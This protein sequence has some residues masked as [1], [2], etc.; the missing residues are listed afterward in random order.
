M[1]E[2]QGWMEPGSQSLSPVSTMTSPLGRGHW[3]S[4]EM[5]AGWWKAGVVRTGVTQRRLLDGRHHHP[6]SRWPRVQAAELSS[7]KPDGASFTLHF[8]GTRRPSS[9]RG[10][11]DPSSSRLEQLPL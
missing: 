3:A 9:N 2:V 11:R 6:R 7:A 10:Y 4:R 1:W 8:G 5:R